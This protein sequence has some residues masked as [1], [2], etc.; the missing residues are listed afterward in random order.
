MDI[1]GG[2]MSRRALLVAVVGVV[3][4]SIAWSAIGIA[5]PDGATLVRERARDGAGLPDGFTPAV[6]KQAP[7]RYFVVMDSPSVAQRLKGAADTSAARAAAAVVHQSQ[8]GA[9]AETRS[10][11][12]NVI[13]RYD[14]LLNGFSA[15]LDREAAER[16]A[17]RPD[18]AAIQPVSVVHQENETSVPFIGAPKVWKGFHARGKGINVAVVDTGVD[19]TH[20]NFGGSGDPKDY[21]NNDPNVIE[22]DSRT[23]R[24][25][26]PTDK[27]TKGFD[28]V[29]SNYDV[30][31]E[32][33]SNDIPRPDP[34]PL[35]RDGHGSHT[36]GTCCGIG[37]P[38]EIGKGVA[39]KAKVWAVKVWDN[40]NS[41]AD[42]LVRGYEFA[43]DPN[44]DG[45]TRDAADVISFSGGVDYGSANSVEA[46]AAQRAVDLGTVFVA[47]AGNSGNQTVGG[48]AYILGTPAS[49]PGVVAVAASIDQFAS[50]TL[51]VNSPEITLPDNGLM[52]PQDWSEPLPQG[53]ITDDLFDGRAIDP[54]SSPSDQM[55]CDP[56]PAGSLTGKVVLVYKGATDDG[57]CD[58]SQKVFN[59][60]NAG[61][62]AVVLVSLFGGLPFG[63]GSG[64]QAIHIPA[65]MVS[66]RDGQAILDTLSPNAPSSYNDT[67]VN[68]TLHDESSVVPGFEDAMTDFTSEGPARVTN[69]L[70]PDIS[71]PGFDIQST[72]VGTGTE[73]TKLSGTSMAAPHISGVA[74][75]LRE[76]HP[77][78]KPG[79]I[80]AVMMNQATR[81]MKNNDLTEPVPATVMGSGRVQ[82]NKSARAVSVARPGSLSFGL[83]HLT[84][85]TSLV[86]KFTVRNFDDRRHRYR[87]TGEDRYSDFD[88]AM[89]D[90][91]VAAG[92]NRF[93]SSDS[94]KLR[95][96]KRRKV[97]VRLTLD[98]SVV[99]EAEQELGWYYF[100]PGMDG[101]IVVHQRGKGGGDPRV[102]W[103][104]TPLAA[105][106]NHLSKSEL[107]LGSGPDH[108]R[109]AGRGAGIDYADLYLLGD[110]SP[111]KS[112]GEEDIV[113]TGAR[114]FTGGN[115]Q[116]GNAQGV[117]TGTDPLAG[118]AWQDFLTDANTPQEPVEIG[119]QTAAVHNVTET[120][121]VDVLVDSGADGVFAGD[122]LGIP[123]DF[124]VV[125]LPQAG[126][127]VC[128]FD[129]S[130]PNPLDSC[131]ELYFPD[132]TNYNGNLFGIVVDARDLGL[133]NANSEFSYGVTA[134]TGTFSGDVPG[135]FCDTAG[136]VS[137]ATG[138]YDA[139]IDVADPALRIS[140]RV[141]GG[142]WDGPDCRAN[143]IVVRRGS[144][145]ASEDPSILALFPNNPPSRDPTIVTTSR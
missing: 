26:F 20:A 145:G 79:L 37:V 77:R 92:G 24:P 125:K 54:A 27:V 87:V 64:G 144:A 48:S 11:G 25:T 22:T 73:G 115:V 57:D 4:G 130:Q 110:T 59:A 109:L 76:I 120:E 70:K 8:E 94:F 97:K 124:L 13:F 69:A 12:G 140:P 117:P 88:P 85:E 35:D 86:R 135:Q 107:D 136:E 126:G 91:Q 95:P 46:I 128:V 93:S 72:A 51:E 49:A 114:S 96:D 36:A 34:D 113:A 1:R 5:S 131:A 53:G 47:S 9:I 62:K 132:Y 23:G 101:T 68:A 143:P 118:I 67:T 2:F 66:D 21:A 100:N 127:E 43:M 30:T 31:D 15:V 112:T 14:V 40:G 39:P 75:L 141:C 38:G 58:G 138:T 74:A 61:A 102:A 78:W 42:V 44:G 116:D 137:D 119:V 65:V 18:V 122:P 83:E 55:F 71:A 19:Y 56:L 80:K 104:V 133:T 16:L 103:G 123:A 89:T 111:L 45:D 81:K 106:K 139:H 32:D 6:A 134:C 41:T 82:A 90:I 98:P 108:M 50:L 60:Q 28:F 17:A 121:E 10:L 105:S 99:S 142:F 52:V 63:L 7:G 3:L 84:D 29:G 129:L 33:P